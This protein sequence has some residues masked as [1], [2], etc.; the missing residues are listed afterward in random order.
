MSGKKMTD[1]VNAPTRSVAV[2]GTD[3][4]CARVLQLPGGD[5][6]LQLRQTGAMASVTVFAGMFEG[7]EARAY[8]AAWC[9]EQ[10]AAGLKG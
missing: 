4:S 3:A 7:G 6:A 2:G 10:L 8:F 1:H 9:E 5:L